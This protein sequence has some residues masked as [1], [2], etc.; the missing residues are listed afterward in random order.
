MANW[1][2]KITAAEA[3]TLD[4]FIECTLSDAE[5]DAEFDDGY[6]LSEGKSF[7]AWGERFVYFAVTYDGAESVGFVPRNPTK[8]D[9]Q[10]GP[11]HWGGE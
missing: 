4:P 1:R 11:I 7:W 9:V 8:P 2:E 3:Y 6:G 5:L 10:L